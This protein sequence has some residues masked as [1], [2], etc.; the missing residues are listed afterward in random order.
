MAEGSESAGY[1]IEKFRKEETKY[2]I[3]SIYAF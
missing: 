1:K 2:G 3:H